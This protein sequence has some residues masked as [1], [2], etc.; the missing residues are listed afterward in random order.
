M[1]F[2]SAGKVETATSTEIDQQVDEKN[3]DSDTVTLDS[4][5]DDTLDGSINEFPKY[6]RYAVVASCFMLQAL[7]CGSIHSWGIQ[8]EYLTA[9][10]FAGDEGRIKTLSY[11][12]TLMYFGVYLWGMLAGWL[13]E[14]W[15]YRKLCFIGVVCLAVGPLA[16]SFCSEVRKIAMP[17]L[18]NTAPAI[19]AAQM[20]LANIGD[21]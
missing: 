6:T 8:Q 1:L 3:P 18:H 7:S 17:I 21:I 13:A 11:I 5:T 14:V 9:H 12:G 19:R 20:C 4:P 2:D 10:D 16:A 15:S